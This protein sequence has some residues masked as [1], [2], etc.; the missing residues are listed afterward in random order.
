VSSLPV[1]TVRAVRVGFYAHRCLTAAVP[2][3]LTLAVCYLTGD[4][5]FC[6]IIEQ[7]CLNRLSGWT[8]SMSVVQSL[9][10]SSWK[11][12]PSVTFGP[13]R[14][15]P[16]W[17]CPGFVHGTKSVHQVERSHRI[18][19][20]PFHVFQD[21]SVQHSERC[22]KCAG[23]YFE[24]RKSILLFMCILYSQYRNCGVWPRM[25]FIQ[26]SLDGKIGLGNRRQIRWI[27]YS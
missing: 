1:Q 23:D 2:W 13:S 10:Y 12:K 18:K 17:V 8:V 7:A 4:P 24:E 9:L 5:N 27:I 25:F 22:E 11:S 14:S 26:I 21:C 16:S 6:S 15:R 20:V 3:G 19:C